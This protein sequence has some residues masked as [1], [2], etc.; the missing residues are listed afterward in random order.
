MGGLRPK[1]GVAEAGPQ[2]EVLKSLFKK[3]IHSDDQ[4]I[5]SHVVLSYK[6]DRPRD[7]GTLRRV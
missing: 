6:T 4:K 3:E 1:L 7:D 2:L 5:I